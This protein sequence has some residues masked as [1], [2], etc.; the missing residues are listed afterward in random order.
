MAYR[1]AL[2]ACRRSQTTAQGWRRQQL[3]E[4]VGHCLTDSLSLSADL[5]VHHT[6]Y[7]PHQALT[8]ESRK[9]L[10]SPVLA[11]TLGLSGESAYRSRCG[12]ELAF[13][14]GH[15]TV[16]RFRSIEGERHYPGEQA[17]HQLRVLVGAHTLD[18]YLG[19]TQR[20][21][22]LDGKQGVRQLA[23][24]RTSSTTLALARA[25]LHDS[26]EPLRNTLQIH[27]HLLRLLAE[28]LGE[29]LPPAI[30]HP[31]CHPRDQQ[32]LD[33]ARRLL[34]SSL[35]TPP[36]IA[37]IARA[38]GLSESKLR[39]GFHH[40]FN[41]SPQRLLLSLRM[42]KAWQLLETGCQVAEAAYAVGYE[43]PSNFSAAFSRFFGCAPKSV[44][45]RK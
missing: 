20:K 31:R 35:S 17:V 41:T 23:Q 16:S 2:D 40:R 5:S 1:I 9:Q 36:S 10:D 14:A 32:K 19:E 11:I 24:R 21:A 44:Y 3:P 43:H 15:T 25:L 26:T 38:V 4:E 29:L 30:S 42:H 8:E 37:D 39:E 34:E 45:A 28:Q 7:A 13:R 6:A 27:I 18:T 33:E 12:A 22:L